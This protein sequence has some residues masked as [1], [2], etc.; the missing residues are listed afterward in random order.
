MR[1]IIPFLLFL[2]ILSYSKANVPKTIKSQSKDDIVKYLRE[3]VSCCRPNRLVGTPSHKKAIPFLVDKI[4]EI[5]KGDTSTLVVH[6]FYPD[7]NSAIKMYKD[8]F[9]T[10]IV[11]KYKNSDP[12]YIKWDLFTQQTISFLKTLKEYRGQNLIW[13]KK[14]S[15]NK[16]LILGAH[17]DTFVSDKKFNINPQSEMPGADDNASGVS[18]LLGIIKA[19]SNVE[20]THNIKIVFFDFHELAQLGSK[21]FL[22]EF[23]STL[24]NVEGFINLLMLGFD[25]KRFDSAKKLGNMKL[26]MSSGNE[27][28]RSLSELLLKLGKRGTRKVKFESGLKDDLV[29]DHKRFNSRGIPSLV[30][31]QNWEN[32]YNS[33]RHHTSDDF[34]ETLNF[35]TLY[36]SYLFIS[37]AVLRWALDMAN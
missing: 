24:T 29:S 22:E 16:T 18:I 34:V 17:I 13:E 7:I 11:S 19:L 5:T 15:S 33:K 9:K 35:D 21:A 14:G 30:F 32:D 37:S 8:D 1:F 36:G 25:S 31:S 2:P 27:Q 28:E 26:Y 10:M 6:E 3:F 4:K 20:L 23:H 12:E